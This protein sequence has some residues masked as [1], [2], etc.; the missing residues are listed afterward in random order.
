[1]VTCAIVSLKMLG[2][3]RASTGYLKEIINHEADATEIRT[4]RCL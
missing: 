4:R 3:S 2:L 1:M